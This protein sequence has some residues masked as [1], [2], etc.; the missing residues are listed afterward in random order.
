M[1]TLYNPALKAP[2]PH[3]GSDRV[4]SF[5]Y[6][7]AFQFVFHFL[8]FSMFLASCQSKYRGVN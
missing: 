3:P 5:L 1:L 2:S 7:I 4:N 8:G 6:D